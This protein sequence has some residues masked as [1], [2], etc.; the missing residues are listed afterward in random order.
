MSKKFLGPLPSVGFEAQVA[1]EGLVPLQGVFSGEFK[2]SSGLRPL[3]TT[4][5]SGRV[6]DVFISAKIGKDDVAALSVE[7]DVYI[8]GSTCL[9]T[10]PKLAH[11]SGE[12]ATE[13][14]TAD[15]RDTG[16][17]QA[18]VNGAANSFEIGDVLTYRLTL[19]RTATPTTEISDVCVVAILEPT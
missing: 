17:T 15:T 13:K 9:A 1:Q 7:A 18:V 5:D 4:L 3:G 2:T 6:R 11:V 16:V 8:N 14:T 10:K 19:V 12:A